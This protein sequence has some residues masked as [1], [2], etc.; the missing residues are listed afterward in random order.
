MNP[1]TTRREIDTFIAM[2][3]RMARKRTPL[4]ASA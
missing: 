3:S 2:L 1:V 4:Q